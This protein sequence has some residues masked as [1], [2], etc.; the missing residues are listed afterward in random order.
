MK[1][2]KLNLITSLLLLFS[3]F[4]YAQDAD[5]TDSEEHS[6]RPTEFSIA[7]LQGVL[8]KNIKNIFEVYAMISF[9]DNW[10]VSMGLVELDTKAKATPPGYHT[11]AWFGSDAPPVDHVS[12]YSMRLVKEFP[13]RLK[14]FKLGVEGGPAYIKQGVANFSMDKSGL[15]GTTRY[16]VSYANKN[17][18]GLTFRAKANAKLNH[19]LGIE[20]AVVSGVN[21]YRSFVSGEIGLFVIL[22]Q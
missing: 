19:Y 15:F 11:S 17:A 14:R 12:S 1:K 22:I 21:R 2:L 10:G 13:T 4:S 8:H 18:L 3:G 5:S 6:V 16:F 9:S 20:T 7:V